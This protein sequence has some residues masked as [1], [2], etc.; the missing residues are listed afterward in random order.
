[1]AAAYSLD[2]RDRVVSAVERGRMSCN[3]AA[4]HFSVAVSTAIRW[5]KVFRETGRLEPGQMGGHKPRKIAGEHRDWL[6]TR[7]QAGDFTLRGLV[8]EL[9]ERGLEVDYHSVWDFVHDE[10]LSFKKNSARQRA[11]SAGRRP[12]AGAVVAVSRAD[13]SGAPGV[14]R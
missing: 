6:I 3:A 13:R 10:N 5:V 12:P 1:M 11:G 8:A 7:C 2:L 14:H 9:A 4:A